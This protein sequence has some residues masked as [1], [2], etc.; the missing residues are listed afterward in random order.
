MNFPSLSGSSLNGIWSPAHRAGISPGDE[1][2][3]LDGY[4][5]KTLKDV[6]ALLESLGSGAT[7]KVSLSRRGRI[8][9]L[10]MGLV[11]E[12]LREW[13]LEEKPKVS[14]RIK[15]RRA[16]WLATRVVAKD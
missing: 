13:K 10:T 16:R 6:S 5:A 12:P 3:A 1:L 7:V 15:R 4:R 2:I 8:L 11:S 9:T 14:K